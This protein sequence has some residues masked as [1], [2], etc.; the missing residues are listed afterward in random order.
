MND[1]VKFTVK[2]GDFTGK[3]IENKVSTMNQWDFRGVWTKERPEFSFES[4]T[5]FVEYMQF[6]TAT[7]GSAARDLFVDPL[8]FNVLDDYDFSPL[9][10]ACRNVLRQGLIP[11]I[12]TG[13]IPVKYSARPAENHEF[14]V[15]IYE[16][17][18]YTVYY[19][20]I[21]AL[22][23]ELAADFGLSC[24]RQWRWGVFT[25]Y[26]NADWFV[27][28][29]T[30]EGAC[31]AYCK[32]YDYTCAALFDVLGDG[33][34]IGAHSMTCA[35]GMWD[36]REFIRHCAEG[37]NYANGGR[38][39]RLC[40]LATSFYDVTPDKHS[41]VQMVESVKILRD[42]AEGYGLRLDYA[43]D[44]GRILF[45]SDSNLPLTSRVVGQTYQAGYDA[46][47]LK[48]MIDGD[49]SWFSTWNYRTGNAFDGI[50]TVSYHVAS[51]FYCMTCTDEV[52]CEKAMSDAAENIEVEVIA[53]CDKEDSIYYALCY[54]YKNQLEYDGTVAVSLK[55]ETP[56]LSGNVSVT[57]FTVDD[58]VNFY[59]KWRADTD[60]SVNNTGWSIDS[61]QPLFPLDVKKYEK[62]SRLSP[63]L[64]VGHVKNGAVELNT[65][66]H[67]NAVVMFIIE[68]L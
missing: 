24:V 68:A 34:Y 32:I 39:S 14:G 67:G 26:E 40:Y 5:P 25:E 64:S 11:F 49:I 28:D 6:M 58:S 19:K 15:N 29:G 62:Y 60:M 13:N 8:N 55:F 53:S 44:E 48:R 2:G 54:A 36:E 56:K 59:P 31:Q 18:D 50:P 37:T 27:G 41:E 16:P 46:H 21:N 22:A 17:K 38:G 47:I 9:V 3:A 45:G 4:E 65:E 61:A 57:S 33:I 43:V 23:R 20:Y 12:K 66:L 42:C 35:E 63:V 51:C 52:K 1:S 10:T 30:K 7:G